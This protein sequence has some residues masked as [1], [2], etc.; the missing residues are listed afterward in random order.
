[1]GHDINADKGGFASRSAC[2]FLAKISSVFHTPELGCRLKIS[3]PGNGQYFFSSR[4]VYSVY[5]RYLELPEK[6]HCGRRVALHKLVIARDDLHIH[7]LTKTSQKC[8][9]FID[10]YLVLNYY[11]FTRPSD[12]NSP[13]TK[14]LKYER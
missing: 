5:K 4:I 3:N 13:M 2:P 14:L 12:F 6:C 9:N 10:V 7:F 1:M 11:F 8:A